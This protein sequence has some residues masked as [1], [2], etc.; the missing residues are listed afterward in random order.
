[1]EAVSFCFHS[2]A[3]SIWHNRASAEAYKDMPSDKGLFD[4]FRE[5]FAVGIGPSLLQERY[6]T[7]RRNDAGELYYMPEEA[8]Y[9]D[10]LKVPYPTTRTDICYDMADLTFYCLS[11]TV[12]DSIAATVD[13]VTSMAFL[14]FDCADHRCLSA[15]SLFL[16]SSCGNIVKICTNSTLCVHGNVSLARRCFPCIKQ[17]LYRTNREGV[18][19]FE[20]Y[21]FHADM[22]AL[23]RGE[24]LP[25]DMAWE[26][27]QAEAAARLSQL[28]AA[29][30]L[31]EEDP[32]TDPSHLNRSQ[33]GVSNVVVVEALVQRDSY[34]QT[35]ATRRGVTSIV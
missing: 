19:A 21:F 13:L 32:D 7:S 11:D 31:Q 28:Q 16:A 20:P 12:I 33:P 14:F 17:K 8:A 23:V 9:E 26:E 15:G 24:R 1:M 25:T 3:N 6:F 29:A 22:R 2:F 27:H 5:G 35:H 34:H 18:P 4:N 10:L 30:A